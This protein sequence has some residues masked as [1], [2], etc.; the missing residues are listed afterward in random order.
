MRQLWRSMIPLVCVAGLAACDSL[1]PDWLGESEKPPL[2]GERI[3]L[4][5]YQ[6]DLVPDDALKDV[7]IVTPEMPVNAAWPQALGNVAAV[8]G[9]LAFSEQP[10]VVDDGTIGEGVGFIS[11][12]IPAPVLAGQLIFAMDGSGTVSAHMVDDLD[13][14][15]WQSSI[16]ASEESGD[17]LIGG[18]LG[19][20]Q[21]ILF[22]VGN[23]GAVAAFNAQTGE[24]LWKKEWLLPL[25]SPPRITPLVVLVLTADNQLLALDRNSGELQWSHQGISEVTLP[26][27]STVPA[28]RDGV[29]LTSYSS[30]EIVALDHETGAPIWSDSI[31]SSSSRDSTKT[32]RHISPLMASG[33]SFAGS[34][35]SISAFETATGRRLWEREVPVADAPWLAGNTL[36]LLTTENEVVAMRGT[37]GGIHWVRALPQPEDETILWHG[38]IV[39]GNKVWIVGNNGMMLGLNVQD[40]SGSGTVEIPS[41]V[42]T[43]PIV[44]NHQMYVV[45]RDAHLHKLK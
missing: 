4:A 35:E 24:M 44:A 36:F 34:S 29:I 20:S 39:A 23:D 22:A 27:H 14:I 3:S 30:G 13:T 8:S 32:F 15:A 33:L 9:N 45:S 5:R 7:E 11:S 37:D 40:G 1:M 21:G 31:M 26:L 12:L 18:G 42:L 28:L 17:T 38:P 6:R 19:Y 2:P 41:G 16:L 25:R 10:S 43:A